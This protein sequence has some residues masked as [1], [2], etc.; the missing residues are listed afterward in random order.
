[1][2]SHHSASR[3][4]VSRYGLVVSEKASEDRLVVRDCDG[5]LPFV[6]A[7][8]AA[9]MDCSQPVAHGD[10]HDLAAHV[11]TKRAVRP[12]ALIKRVSA[13]HASIV[14]RMQ[15]NRNLVF[16]ALRSL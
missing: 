14:R 8:R 5:V 9:V 12:S 1:M 6:Q 16:T 4:V 13:Q 7:L 3:S 15:T 11:E 10:A 2:S